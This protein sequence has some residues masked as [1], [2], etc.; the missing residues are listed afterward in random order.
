MLVSPNPTDYQVH[1]DWSEFATSGKEVIIE[2]TNQAG[3]LIELL[4]PASGTTGMDWTTEKVTG[5]SCYY[6][7]I[8]NGQEVYGG[9]IVINK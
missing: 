1:F 4:H 2:V 7:L 3:G 6:R 8:V 5:N 9:Q